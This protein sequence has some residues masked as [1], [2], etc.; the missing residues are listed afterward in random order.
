MTSRKRVSY[1]HYCK[2]V[3]YSIYIQYIP[4]QHGMGLGSKGEQH[5]YG[6]GGRLQNYYNTGSKGNSSHCATLKVTATCDGFAVWYEC[7]VWYVGPGW[8]CNIEGCKVGG[9][10][11]SEMR[12]RSTYSRRS[13]IEA[14]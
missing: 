6:G 13:T 8:S 2:C 11:A 3:Q 5:I 14:T 4:L 9:F 12:R 7:A 1:S 10:F